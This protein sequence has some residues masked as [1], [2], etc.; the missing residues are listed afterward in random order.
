MARAGRDRRVAVLGAGIMGCCL[1]LFLARRGISVALFD[2]QR[3][4]LEGAS[5]WNEGKIHLGY[6]YGADASLAT[7]R[8][9]LP[10]GLQFKPL[11][12]QLIERPLDGH[13]THG[14]DLFLIH[15][16]SVVDA[17]AA[18]AYYRAVD[19]IVQDSA[20]AGTYLCDLRGA[21]TRALS[22]GE[23]GAVADPATVRAG[24]S[25]PERS[26]QTHWLAD[27][28]REAVAANQAIEQ[29]MGERVTGLQRDGDANG[30]WQVVTTNGSEAFGCVANALWE[31]RPAIDAQAGLPRPAEWSARYRLALFVTTRTALDAPSAVLG[32]GPFGDVKN[33]NGRDFYLS[34]YPAGLVHESDGAGPAGGY[35]VPPFDSSAVEAATRE[36]LAA[37]LG[38]VRDILA[39]SETT[40]VGGG[41]VVAQGRGPLSSPA[42]TL[43]RRDAFGVSRSGSYY[44]IDTGK[45]STAP[46]L[47]HT[48]AGEI[49]AR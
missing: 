35:S 12:E 17:G 22:P 42:S 49:A 26:V 41:W 24:F 30:Q 33:Y 21:R 45:Y 38:W 37:A 46:W 11:V 18:H 16:D 14:D 19:A 5:R 48:L 4:P 34:W 44:S 1:A 25:V 2:G 28:L 15:R 39:A 6:L 13:V 32:V 47:A 7:A 23:L 20:G 36:G 8:H 27:R 40:R 29:R 9:L 43:H 10:G 31:G 3:R